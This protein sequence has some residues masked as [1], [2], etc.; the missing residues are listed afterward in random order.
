MINDPPEK[1]APRAK[2]DRYERLEESCT[3]KM[4]MQEESEP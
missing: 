2:E 3:C 4:G 1:K